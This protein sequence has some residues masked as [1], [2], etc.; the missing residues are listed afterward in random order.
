MQTPVVGVRVARARRAICK[1]PRR[2]TV[3]S[4][5]SRRSVWKR[6]TNMRSNQP[7]AAVA[8]CKSHA[9]LCV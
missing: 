8:A 9:H 5:A 3:D 4:N 7:L 1:P 2:Q 6:Y